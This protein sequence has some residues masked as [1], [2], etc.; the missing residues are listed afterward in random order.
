M[1]RVLVVDDEATYRTSIRFAL[2]NHGF[3]VATA[4]GIW[5]AVAESR[6]QDPDL[7]ICDWI[8]RDGYRGIDVLKVLRLSRSRLP[9]ILITG[10][11]DDTDLGTRTSEFNQVIA[12][13]FTIA[14]LLEVMN[15]VIA[16]GDQ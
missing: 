4:E 8:L 9:G 13:P 14:Q 5:D 3:D 15:E 10:Y 2:S 11:P 16:S 6:R 12:K 7:L 1:L